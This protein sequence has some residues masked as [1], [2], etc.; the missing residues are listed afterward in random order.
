MRRPTSWPIWSVPLRIDQAD[1]VPPKAGGLPVT[2]S[3]PRDAANVLSDKLVFK[4]QLTPGAGRDVWHPV[5]GPPGH[6]HPASSRRRKSTPSWR[7]GLCSGREDEVRV[8]VDRQVREPRVSTVPVDGVDPQSG[9]Q[10]RN[11]RITQSVRPRSGTGYF[12]NCAAS[13]TGASQSSGELSILPGVAR[14]SPGASSSAP[15]MTSAMAWTGGTRAIRRR[16]KNCA[17]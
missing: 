7:S 13:A 6:G 10:V 1:A 16:D 3:W 5:M 8:S 14:R 4:P 2:G 15:I 11:S 12:A 17:R 9:Q